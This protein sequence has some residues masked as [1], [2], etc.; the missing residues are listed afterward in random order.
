MSGVMGFCNFSGIEFGQAEQLGI[1]GEMKEK[2]KH[3]GDYAHRDFQSTSLLLA[4]AFHVN[5]YGNDYYIAFEGELYNSPEI[6]EILASRGYK[7]ET[8]TTEEL[9]LRAYVHYGI[10]V[11]NELNG[12]FAM[13]VY[14]KEKNSLFLSRDRFGTKPLFFTISDG[15]LVFAS[16]IKALFKYPKVRPV[17]D[18][19]SI[20]EIFGLGPARTEGFGVF[21][22]IFEIKQGHFASCSGSEIKQHKYFDLV[23]QPHCET[24]EQTVE[25]AGALL[26][27]AMKRQLGGENIC[28]FLSGGLDS[29]V[30]TAFFAQNQNSQ[31]RIETISFDF[32]DNDKYFK[33]SGFQPD[34]DRPWVEKMVNHSK[35]H[36][37]FLFC[38]H[39]DLAKN[40]YQSV[41]AK[42]LPGMADVDSS[43]LYFC[44]EV[45]K[46]HRIALTG[47]C[48]DEIFAGYPWFHK[49]EML[50]TKGFPWSPSLVFRKQFLRDDILEKINLDEYVESRYQKSLQSV[51]RLDGESESDAKQREVC[52]LNTKWFMSTLIDR[53][54]RASSQFGLTARVPFCDYRLVSYLYNVPYAYKCKDGVVKSILRDIA[55]D[56]LPEELLM[57]KKSPYPKTYNPYY[58]ELLADSLR[59]VLE[60]KDAP[61]L[62]IVDKQKVLNFLEKESNVSVP[63]YGQLMATP[64][65]IAYLLQIN[66]W[67]EEYRIEIEL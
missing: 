8:E 63:W 47:E 27:D 13:A 24:Y 62:K 38:D 37:T 59:D 31:E 40:L 7:F 50:N 65:M 18:K 41:S 55:K 28:C 34:L 36:H 48:S 33:S 20:C 17:V 44:N 43:L 11:V 54:D 3:R 42:D 67:L 60:N 29:S 16:E 21:K 57:R 64:Q 12:V 1:L 25:H 39:E 35:T 14:D 26:K 53:M 58:T 19:N 5:Y 52:Y 9:I 2:L 51:P 15:T 46:T 30:I 4:N 66:F 56:L 6:K 22:N 49:E 10:N 23:A 32:V 61:I 45:S